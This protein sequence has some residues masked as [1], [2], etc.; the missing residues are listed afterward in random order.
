VPRDRIDAIIRAMAHPLRARVYFCVS[1]SGENG[2]AVNSLATKLNEPRRRVRYHIDALAEQGLVG[3]SGER[4]R[5]GVVERSYYALHPPDLENDDLDLASK[6]QTE[7]I[8]LGILR[9]IVE[10]VSVAAKSGQL[11]QNSGLLARPDLVIARIPAELDEQGWAEVAEIHSQ[12]IDVVQQAVARCRDRL[13]KS[14][15]QSISAVSGLLFFPVSDP[16]SDT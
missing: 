5:R 13:E 15:E 14:G 16:Q 4:K 2:I 7:R 6:E 8:L 11:F 1:D 10:D 12:T 3:V 9:T